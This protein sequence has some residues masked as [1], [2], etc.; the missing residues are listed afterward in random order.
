MRLIAASICEIAILGLGLSLFLVWVDH[1]K[2]TSSHAATKYRRKSRRASFLP[3]TDLP[4][5]PWATD[6]EKLLTS[7]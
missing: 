1:W 4:A 5:D 3:S 7:K 6:G 2:T